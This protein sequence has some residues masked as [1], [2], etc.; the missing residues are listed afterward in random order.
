MDLTIFASGNPNCWV[1]AVRGG[2]AEGNALWTLWEPQYG[3]YLT[4]FRVYDGD[5][6][7]LDQCVYGFANAY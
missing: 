7:M 4:L 2:V 1:H 5:G 3:Y 6:N